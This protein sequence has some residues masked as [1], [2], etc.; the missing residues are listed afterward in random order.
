MGFGFLPDFGGRRE[1]WRVEI[2]AW[3][4]KDFYK[5]FWSYFILSYCGFDIYFIRFKIILLITSFN[6]EYKITTFLIF[7]H[8]F[9]FTAE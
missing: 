2:S 9:S 5:T 1:I 8:L 6:T 7:Y 3:T 4:P